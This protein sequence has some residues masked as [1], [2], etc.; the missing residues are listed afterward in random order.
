VAHVIG[1][2]PHFLCESVSISIENWY[3]SARVVLPGSSA[4]VRKLCGTIHSERRIQVESVS[5][6][7]LLRSL[8]DRS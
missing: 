7:Q 6:H 4:Q 2:N 8:P 3:M 5:V 1:D